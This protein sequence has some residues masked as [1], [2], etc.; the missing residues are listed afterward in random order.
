MNQALILLLLALGAHSSSAVGLPEMNPVVRVQQQD[1]KS[2]SN[3]WVKQ[4][5]QVEIQSD[6]TAERLAGCL[7][8]KTKE[9]GTRKC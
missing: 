7:F 4:I 2:I 5:N 6:G 1:I 8:S 3:K 9:G